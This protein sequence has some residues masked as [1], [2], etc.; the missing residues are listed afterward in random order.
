MLRNKGK[1]RGKNRL[2]TFPHHPTNTTIIIFFNIYNQGQAMR[3][4]FG[5]IPKK[6]DNKPR[7]KLFKKTKSFF[8]DKKK[9]SS[10][11]KLK[12]VRK[13]SVRIGLTSGGYYVI[14]ISGVKLWNKYG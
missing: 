12:K 14:I 5:C 6:Q 1:E 8:F 2:S 9:Q 4:R 7:A 11:I 13:K 10:K 3:M